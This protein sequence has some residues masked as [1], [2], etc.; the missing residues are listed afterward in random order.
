MNMYID[1]SPG[2]V[3]S[4][5]CFDESTVPGQVALNNLPNLRIAARNR[6]AHI[7]GRW[8]LSC[9]AWLCSD[10]GVQSTTL[11]LAAFGVIDHE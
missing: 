4:P 5:I 3:A 9:A 11:S 6:A 8:R 2:N 1:Y 7:L 10:I